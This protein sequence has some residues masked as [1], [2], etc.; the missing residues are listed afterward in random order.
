MLP[1]LQ[2]ESP[3]MHHRL[4]GWLHERRRHDR[5]WTKG[6]FRTQ[7]VVLVAQSGHSRQPSATPR[8][9]GKGGKGGGRSLNPQSCTSGWLLNQPRGGNALNCRTLRVPESPSNTSSLARRGLAAWLLQPSQHRM[10]QSSR[11]IRA[12]KGKRNSL[13]FEVS[14]KG[15][16]DWCQT[17]HITDH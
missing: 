15:E 14:P 16:F 17:H 3:Q 6:P 2:P 11:R 10:N 12:R 13:V 9:I 1:N 4:T 8:W 7:E 5:S